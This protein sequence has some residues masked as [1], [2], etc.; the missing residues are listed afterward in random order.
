MQVECES[1]SPNII[2]PSA[3]S[4]QIGPTIGLKIELLIIVA[5][6]Q[7]MELKK[8]SPVAGNWSVW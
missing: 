5:S 2:N 4:P 1:F 6:N 3:Y 7:N 8:Y